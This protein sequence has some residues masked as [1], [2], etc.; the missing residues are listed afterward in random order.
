[1]SPEI[2]GWIL[3][4]LGLLLAFTGA[5]LFWL[6]VGI[7]GFAF[8]W[9]VTLLLFPNVEPLAG[10]LIGLVLGAACALPCARGWAAC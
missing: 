10:F 9:L 6:A 1:M 7:A 2:G 5:R 8:G 4:G 3:V